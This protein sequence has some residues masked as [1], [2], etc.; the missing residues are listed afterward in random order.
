MREGPATPIRREDYA[1]PAFWIRSVE[2]SF[3]LEPAKT[4][5]ASKLV[6][7]RDPA[8]AP[9]QALKLHG[10]GLTLLRCQ[11]NGESVSFRHEGGQ[12]VIDNPP[13]DARFTLDIRIDVATGRTRALWTLIVTLS[14]SRYQFVWPT[15]LQ[16][17][18]GVCEAH[19]TARC[20][21][22][23]M[24]SAVSSG[25]LRSYVGQSAAADADTH[26]PQQASLPD[27]LLR[28][29]VLD[30]G[31]PWPRHFSGWPGPAPIG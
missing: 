3:D 15:F 24:C 7:E 21:R 17:T 14:F 23:T 29:R 10:E 6:I 28:S 1:A 30:R 9:G 12:L 31:S 11:A 8:A 19:A 18:E 26:A 2:L 5:V 4:I 25:L 16:T 22:T 20:S 27:P 13:T